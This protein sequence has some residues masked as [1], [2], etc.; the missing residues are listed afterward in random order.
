MHS[1]VDIHDF[2]IRREYFNWT[3]TR[4]LK[5]TVVCCS[6]VTLVQ[7]K[8]LLPI[9][10]QTTTPQVFKKALVWFLIEFAQVQF[11]M[12]LAKLIELQF[13]VHSY[14]DYEVSIYSSACT[15]WQT[16]AGGCSD[17]H[18]LYCLV[19]YVL[20]TEALQSTHVYTYIYSTQHALDIAV[21][22]FRTSLQ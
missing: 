10:E 3:L 2:V 15:I 8:R 9:W 4:N 12:L 13:T 7:M 20:S 19:E 1:R 16:P 11:E 22:Y 5:D 18:V 14:C 17:L 6:P 21:H